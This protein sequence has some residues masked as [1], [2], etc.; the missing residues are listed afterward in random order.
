M[1][2]LGCCRASSKSSAAATCEGTMRFAVAPAVVRQATHR[3]HKP[4]KCRTREWSPPVNFAKYSSWLCN[5]AYMSK[6]APLIL[7]P[8]HVAMTAPNNS[9]RPPS[10]VRCEAGGAACERA[11]RLNAA[12]N[13]SP[14]TAPLSLVEHA[15]RPLSVSRHVRT[16][17]RAR[18]VPTPHK[19]FAI[20]TARRMPLAASKGSTSRTTSKSLTSPLMRMIR[21]RHGSGTFSSTRSSGGGKVWSTRTA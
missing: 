17:L 1:S 18:S 3:V 6:S 4:N 13:S 9:T 12:D 16:R 8:Q 5:W 15:P 19:C 14:G 7:C 20:S 2:S 21:D 11:H 10:E